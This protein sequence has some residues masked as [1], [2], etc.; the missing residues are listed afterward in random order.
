MR[1]R[2]RH[3]LVYDLPHT[4]ISRQTFTNFAGKLFKK[5]Q[6][7][8]TATMFCQMQQVP[9]ILY[10]GNVRTAAAAAIAA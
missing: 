3:R 2:V 9:D 10:R 5:K 7:Q 8:G 4:S 1:S 6:E